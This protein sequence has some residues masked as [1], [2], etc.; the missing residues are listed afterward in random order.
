MRALV[1]KLTPS[2]GIGHS[3]YWLYNLLL[4]VIVFGFVYGDLWPFALGIILLSKWRMLAVRP[5]FWFV[6]IRSNAIDIVF[7]LSMLAFMT[8]TSN[9]IFQAGWVVVWA[10][11]L[12]LIKPRTD[13]F[14]VSAQAL[15]GFIAG[16]TTLFIEWDNAPL[17]VL[18]VVSG[19]M[20]Y[21]AAHHFFSTFDEQYVRLL[22]LY[23]AFFGASLTWILGH[24]LIF[25]GP[26]AQPT[27]LLSALAVGMGTIYYFDHMD[28]LSAN[29]RRQVIFIMI[30]LVLI[31]LVFSNWGDKIV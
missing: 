26:I 31:V 19:L 3:F 15:L 18:V 25:Y 24:W 13:T 23:W 27:L 5:R 20:C 9:I 29:V 12:L 2:R 4:P 14:W 7:G 10:I 8:Q 22:A 28:K 6:N 17:A 21:V 16:M 11:W 30:A 1:Q